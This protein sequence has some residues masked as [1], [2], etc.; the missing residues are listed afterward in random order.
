M[1]VKIDTHHLYLPYRFPIIADHEVPQKEVAVP[2][3]T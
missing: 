2:P 1:K 3:E